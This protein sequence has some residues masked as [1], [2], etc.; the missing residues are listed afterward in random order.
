M[1]KKCLIKSNTDLNPFTI[2]IWVKIC[3]KYFVGPLEQACQTQNPVRAAEDVLK[4]KKV[5]CGPQLEIFLVKY[6]C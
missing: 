1:I 2:K 5:V 3:K 6:L 4:P